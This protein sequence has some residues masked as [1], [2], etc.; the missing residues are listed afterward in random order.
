VLLGS[1]GASGHDRLS[2]A[3]QARGLELVH[4]GA[5]SL[6]APPGSLV[7]AQAGPWRVWIAGRI[8]AVDP[9]LTAAPAF[10]GP[11]AVAAAAL[12]RLG[13]E[14]QGRLYG[15][16]LLVA[17]DLRTQTAWVS[18]DHLGARTLVHT[19][20]DRGTL[21]AE[22]VADL[23]SL[24]PA[25]PVP[26]RLA[27]LH[28]IDRRTLPGD[29]SL[30]ESVHRLAPGFRLE[31]TASGDARPRPFWRPVYREP[32]LTSA[33]Q[34]A[35][36]VREHAFAAV[37]RAASGL[38]NPGVKLSGGLDSACV[39]AGLAACAE[40]RTPVALAGVF[41]DY[42]EA[43][44]SVLIEQ[45]ARAVGIKLVTVVHGATEVFAP[46]TGYIRRWAVPPWSPM[47]AVWDPLMAAARSAQIDGLL[48]GEGGD[49]LFGFTPQLIADRLLCGRLLSAWRLSGQLPGVGANPSVELRL[50]IL[51]NHG[52]AT[53]L[54]PR[55]R[56][57]RRR[58]S[59]SHRYPSQLLFPPDASRLLAADEAWAWRRADG[60]LW[61]RAA[62]DGLVRDPHRV[63]A[64][65][66]LRH[67]ALDAGVER[68]HPFL[69]DALLVEAMLA[70]PPEQLFDPIRT[71]PLLR[72]GLKGIIPD[73]VRS[74]FAKSHFTD[75][76]S[77]SMAGP[78]GVA[79]VSQLAD[80]QA[81]I[82]AYVRSR[83]LDELA[84][85]GTTSGIQRHQLSTNLFRL[86]S[87]NAWLLHLEG[88]G[89]TVYAP[90]G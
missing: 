58:I 83:P 16:Y 14:G 81:P 85:I 80:P 59:G 50:R 32:D 38:G 11:A 53:A 41:P 73:T 48:D 31:L 47:T 49:E 52:V 61:W 9:P 39:A 68:R 55:A 12:E 43:D 18:H 67:T 54:P 75:L 51:R 77:D 87:V 69:H 42:P 88:P 63:D 13:A 26:D 25:T 86:A 33:E 27:L 8:D 24:M 34:S 64:N 4:D 37:R 70:R 10:G 82:R 62:L 3:A 78:E 84:A 40:G 56:W 90:S 5:L 89:P 66:E 79:L 21:F 65:A 74:R 22:E 36:A 20:S 46:V 6:A 44:E 35:A 57:L 30:Y 19:A 29:R 7:E 15:A 23:L 28:W 60:P 45:T 71:R 17:H 72:D 2:V 76:I 1:W